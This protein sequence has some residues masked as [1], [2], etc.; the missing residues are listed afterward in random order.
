[1]STE[2]WVKVRKFW[3]FCA[4]DWSISR[5]KCPFMH[6]VTHIWKVNV[7]N[8]AR[9]RYGLWGKGGLWVLGQKSLWPES[10]DGIFYGLWQV[11]GYRGYGLRQVRLYHI[12]VRALWPR[13]FLRLETS[14]TLRVPH[15]G[16]SVI[17][18]PW[19]LMSFH[20]RSPRVH[21][22]PRISAYI[23]FNLHL[24]IAEFHRT[25]A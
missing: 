16:L 5:Q 21:C 8:F 22:T 1:M 4:I 13:R 7:W 18:V 23:E 17:T 3:Y 11:M 25:H 2:K 20:S 9:Q 15:A 19:N 12:P 6:T 24:F 14:Q 10:V